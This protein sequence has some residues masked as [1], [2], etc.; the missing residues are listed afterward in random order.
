MGAGIV[1]KHI[2]LIYPYYNAPSMLRVH[3]KNWSLMLD[4]VKERMNVILVDDGSRKSP[5]LDAVREEWGKKVPE[6]FSLFR[7]I[8]D[9]PWNQ[10]GARNLGAKH[11][12]KGWMLISDIDHT[13]SYNSLKWILDHDLDE[14]KYY[15]LRRMTAVPGKNELEIMRD[16]NGLP[17]PHPNSFILT[18]GLYW[19]VGGYDEDYCGTY[20]GDGPFRRWLDRL[21]TRE[22]L[23]LPYLVRWPREVIPDASQSSEFREAYRGKFRPLFDRKGGGEAPKPINPLRFKWER[24]L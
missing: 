8:E 18:K 13:I 20:G 23:N 11:A 19:K 24:V 15:T 4:D 7:I 2:T 21:A 9:I 10:H 16:K 5:A 22:H 3:L 6:W 17:K 12:H 14:K 1:I